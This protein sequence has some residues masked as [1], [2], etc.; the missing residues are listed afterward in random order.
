MIY[1]M[2]YRFTRQKENSF[3]VDWQLTAFSSIN[4]TI[5]FD[6]EL[7][8]IFVFLIGAVICCLWL[9]ACLVGPC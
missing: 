5:L 3:V 8:V 1:R 7:Y 4:V 9:F 2:I 6:I